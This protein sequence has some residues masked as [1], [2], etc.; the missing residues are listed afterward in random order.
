MPPVIEEKEEE[1]VI[2]YPG[3]VEGLLVN[4]FAVPKKEKGKK[5]KKK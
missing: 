1:F 2:K 4:P 5:K 3:L